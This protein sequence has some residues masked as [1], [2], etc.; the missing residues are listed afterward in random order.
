MLV[1]TCDAPY[2]AA[3]AILKICSAQPNGDD[4]CVVYTDDARRY[5]VL[6]SFT[7][8]VAAWRAALVEA[9]AIPFED[10]GVELEPAPGPR[11]APEW[12]PENV[13]AAIDKAIALALEKRDAAVAEP[14]LSADAEGALL[15]VVSTPTE[16]TNTGDATTTPEPKA[17]P[18]FGAKP[19]PKPKRK[20]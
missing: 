13:E 2:E 1:Q 10:G 4:R 19:K 17:K 9:N 8:F 15:H 7:K 18:A 14:T 11:I 5:N 16:V 12:A 6:L 3:I 20:R